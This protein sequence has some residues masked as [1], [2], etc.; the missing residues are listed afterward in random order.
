MNTQEMSSLNIFFCSLVD[1]TLNFLYDIC[2]IQNMQW[3]LRIEGCR[4]YEQEK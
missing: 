2:V 3:I 4:N 1:I